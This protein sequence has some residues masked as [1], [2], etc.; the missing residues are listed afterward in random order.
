VQERVGV[1]Q[2]GAQNARVIQDSIIK[3]ALRFIGQL[4]MAVFGSLDQEEHVWASIFLGRPGFM[5]AEDERLVN[6]DLTTLVHNPHD[7]FWKN[8]QENPQVGMLAI[9][10]ASRRRLRINGTITHESEALL[11][12][13]VKES[14]P[15]CPK[16]IQRRQ[17]STP[18]QGADMASRL[19]AQGAVLGSEQRAIIAKA[20]T[21]F[22]ASVHPERGV[23]ASHRGGNPGFVTLVDDHTLRIP[24]YPGNSMFNTLGNFTANPR[25]GL[26]FLDFDS[27]RT[28]Q[29]TGQSEILYDVDGTA[30]ETGGTNRHWQLHIERWVEIS[31]AQQFDWEFQDYSPYNFPVPSSVR[32]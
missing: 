7:P 20:D 31:L 8:I 1:L 23:D 9:E 14:Y 15:N 29:L 2:E 17:G 16:Y 5:Q 22:V 13:Q 3:G 12:L 18:R 6:F 25:A 24:D 30:E 28:L 21:F 19:S 11:Q 10:L 26:I 4:P 27:H 32:A